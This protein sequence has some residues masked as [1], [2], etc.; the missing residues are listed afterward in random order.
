MNYFYADD[1]NKKLIKTLVFVHT[2]E[3]K[4]YYNS[5]HYFTGLIPSAVKADV[6]HQRKSEIPTINDKIT[7]AQNAGVG[8][9]KGY[10]VGQEL[11][12]EIHQYAVSDLKALEMETQDAMS[13]SPS[14]IVRAIQNLTDDEILAK[15]K[16]QAALN[17]DLQVGFLQCYFLLCDDMIS[18]VGRYVSA[19]VLMYFS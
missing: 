11:L 8:T 13:R 15:A 7:D 1:F 9:D 6:V 2:R 16:Q 19:N 17:P 3:K 5:T 12:N 18:V 14:G 10:T 4:E